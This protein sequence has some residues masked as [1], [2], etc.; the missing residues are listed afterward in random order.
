MEE[1]HQRRNFLLL[2]FIVFIWGW[3]PIFGRLISIEAFQL[4]WFRML[5]TIVFVGGYLFYIRQNLKISRKVFLQLFTIGG[6]IAFHWFCFYHAI[7]ISNVSVTLAAF[8][9]GTLFTAIFEPIF[10]KRKILPYEIFFGLIIIGAIM[11]ILQV[12]TKYTL[13]IFYGILA[14]VTSS[15]FTVWNGLM[16]R[17]TE[18]PTITFYELCG[19]F[20]CLSVYLF[21]NGDFSNSFFIV[22]QTDIYWLLLFSSIGTAFPFIA[23]VNL[24]KKINPYTVTLTVNLETV[25]GIIWAYFLFQEHKQVTIYFYIGTA[26]ILATIFANAALKKY[27]RK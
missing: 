3:S 22:P 2:H 17:K 13:G 8:S 15:F 26:I 11:M 23:S 25:Y 16:V 7:K 5:M 9:T 27:L 24:L 19:G 20:F 6:I 21:F 14:A 10:Y 4:V 18:S 12:E 1:Q